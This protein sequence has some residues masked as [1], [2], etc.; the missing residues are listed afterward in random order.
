VDS[1]CNQPTQQRKRSA[2]SNKEREN[3]PKHS[4]RDRDK[5][6]GDTD[7]RPRAH[8]LTHE[9]RESPRKRKLITNQTRFCNTKMTDFN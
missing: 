6:G 2:S 4:H 5:R 1:E 7:T 3:T 9:E 8:V